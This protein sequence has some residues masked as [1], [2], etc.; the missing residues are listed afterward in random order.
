MRLPLGVVV[1]VF[2]FGLQLLVP[3]MSS[4]AAVHCTHWFGCPETP[5][6][7]TVLPGTWVQSG[8]AAHGKHVFAVGLA[9]VRSHREAPAVLQS[10]LLKH[11]THL[12]VAVLHC[13][14]A[15]VVQWALLEH[16]TQVFVSV[17]QTGV[18]PPQSLFSR[19]PTQVFAVVAVVAVVDFAVVSHTGLSG[20]L[21]QS[22]LDR[23]CTH[24]AASVLQSG[25][26][27]SAQW[28]SFVHSTHAFVELAPLHA[29]VGALQ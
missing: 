3:Q 18:V 6:R 5:A 23:H 27:E 20:T 26:D 28:A 10:A 1:Q 12:W 8:S 15:A 14:F 2:V 7:Q 25:F 13:G 17:L 4:S 21:A 24:F 11:A 16:S 9:A 29:G 19:Q 22:L